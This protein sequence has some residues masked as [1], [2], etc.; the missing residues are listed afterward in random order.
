[1]GPG[2]LALFASI[3]YGAADF[4]GGLGV[5]RSS[6]LLT[7]AISQLA[8]LICLV[9]VA[10]VTP[11]TTIST[12]DIALGLTAGAATMAGLAALYY[13]LA[14]GSMTIVAPITAL[15]AIALPAIYQQVDQRS[16][17]SATVLAGIGLAA[18]ACA[19][20]GGG[21]AREPGAPEDRDA[22]NRSLWPVAIALAAG[23][24]IATF[25][26][27]M[28]AVAPGAGLW[29]LVTCRLLS[30]AMF[31]L[32]LLS[33]RSE[34]A[35]IRAGAGIGLAAAAGGFDG[36]ANILFLFAVQ[37][38]ELAVVSTLTSLY[39]ATT[40]V[41]AAALLRERLTARQVSGLA[42]AVI[43]VVALARTAIS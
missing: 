19:L 30:A 39:P 16:L 1:M 38:G 11:A 43:S 17:A 2:M 29:P 20:I 31:G 22:G 5:R 14:N 40:I 24:C 27:A 42:F 41:L 8:A 33:R 35:G 13:G 21:A 32:L 36:L 28:S 4:L 7:L 25:C 37:G 6:L 15:T 12:S 18:F 23:S 3:S 34:L 9:P 26:I 10:I